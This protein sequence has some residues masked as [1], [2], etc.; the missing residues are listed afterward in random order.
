[1]K[2]ALLGVGETVEKLDILRCGGFLQP[3][4]PL[5]KLKL[6]NHGEVVGKRC[7]VSC[8]LLHFVVDAEVSCIIKQSW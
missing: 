6:V 1:M 3:G 2:F 8:K 7:L 4:E 5:V